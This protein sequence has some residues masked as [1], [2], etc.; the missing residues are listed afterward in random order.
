MVCILPVKIIKLMYSI[1]REVLNALVKI[2]RVHSFVRYGPVYGIDYIR[3]GYIV[4]IFYPI[5]DGFVRSVTRVR[6]DIIY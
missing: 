3:V 4:H 1:S 5:I 6:N 2:K